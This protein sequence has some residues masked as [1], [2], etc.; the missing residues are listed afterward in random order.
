MEIQVRGP[1]KEM[2]L[3]ARMAIDLYGEE[4]ARQA[5]REAPFSLSDAEIDVLFQRLHAA[6]N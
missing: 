4:A 2:T 5:F 1:S 6:D 3:A